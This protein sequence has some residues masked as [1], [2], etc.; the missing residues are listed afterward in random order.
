[1]ANWEITQILLAVG[2]KL[3]VFT[4]LQNLSFVDKIGRFAAVQN[5]N[6]CGWTAS[7]LISM[8]S[9]SAVSPIE[10]AFFAVKVIVQEGI[11]SPRSPF[12]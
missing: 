10:T 9:F 6:C 11:G 2:K 12:S 7:P 3:F 5:N 1:M 8:C 4:K